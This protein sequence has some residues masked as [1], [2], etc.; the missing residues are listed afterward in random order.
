MEHNFYEITEISKLKSI[1][2]YCV[3]ITCLLQNLQLRVL[4]LTAV[5]TY[6]NTGIAM[7][8]Q[9]INY[10]LLIHFNAVIIVFIF[11]G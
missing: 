3:T 7:I 6:I 8:L 4:K 2:S 10:L 9:S 5:Y 11:T 1:Q